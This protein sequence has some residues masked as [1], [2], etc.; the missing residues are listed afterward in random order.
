M[1]SAYEPTGYFTLDPHAKTGD[2]SGLI[3]IDEIASR[4]YG[5]PYNSLRGCEHDSPNLCNGAE[6]VYDFSSEDDFEEALEQFDTP[7]IYLGWDRESE[8]SV[9]KEG[10]TDLDYWLSIKIAERPEDVTVD[11]NPPKGTDL[12]GVVFESAFF[13][14]RAF[15]PPLGEVVADLIRRGELPRGNYIYRHWW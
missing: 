12:E 2:G 13:A 6:K 9:V 10:M 7:E 1:T 5:K 4:V 8:E 15:T 11:A 3:P 14:D